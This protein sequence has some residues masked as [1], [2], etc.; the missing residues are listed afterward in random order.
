MHSKAE[1]HPGK[2]EKPDRWDRPNRDKPNRD[3]PI[4]SKP[5]YRN[6]TSRNS[7]KARAYPIMTDWNHCQQAI[8]F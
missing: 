8:G 7:K 4:R 1:T 3:K 2:P 6:R 5:P